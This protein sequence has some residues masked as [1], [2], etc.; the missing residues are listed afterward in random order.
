MK[1]KKWSALILSALLLLSTT[2][3]NGG[4]GTASGTEADGGGSAAGENEGA[5][6]TEGTGEKKTIT[7]SQWSAPSEDDELNLYKQFELA[8]PEYTVEVIVIAEDQ[9]SA[10]INQMMATNTAPD[11]VLAW[12]CD[13]P[14]F[15]A[16]GKVISLDSYIEQ[17]DTV[18]PDDFIPAVKEMSDQFGGN[19]ALPWCYASEILFYNKDMFDEANVPYPTNDWTMDDF[20]EAAE[21]LTVI[22]DSGRVQ[23]YGCDGL[24]FVGGWWSG[25]GAAG[26]PVYE[27]GKLVIGDGAKKFLTTQKYLVDNQISPAPSAESSDLF[28][29]GMAAMTRNGSWF[30]GTY[31]D[32]EF[33]WD[34][35]PQPQD[36]RFYNSLHTGMW[37]IP[38]S[39]EDKDAAWQALEWFMG[40]EGQTVLSKSSGN[41][42]VTKSIADQGAWKV[43]GTNGP[44]NWDA[45][46]VVSDSGVFGYV[47][48]PAGLTGDAVKEFEAAVL[49]QKTIDEAIADVQ[50][51]AED[52]S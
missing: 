27:D 31:K 41:I 1:A 34:I 4:S 10:K 9:Y 22:D 25:I 42:S 14:S 13:I 43:Q 19:Y 36:T 16:S 3:C 2:A 39:T 50:A 20:V 28:A 7:V 15:V 30:L 52:F 11:I 26:D 48:L 47:C 29:S 5:S 24:T 38:E 21:K 46:D 8:Y 23:Q 49:G 51:E 32:L 33:N 45:F 37:C 40:E 44:S 35:A 12:E 17:S 6:E 18:N